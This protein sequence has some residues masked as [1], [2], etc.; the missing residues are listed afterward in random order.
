MLS[1]LR[2]GA[3]RVTAGAHEGAVAAG[4][5]LKES[6]EHLGGVDDLPG[7]QAQAGGG[8]YGQLFGGTC[9]YSG[10]CPQ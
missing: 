6:G 9:S 10:R 5:D 3:F 8:G 1:G 7:A 4:E 2:V